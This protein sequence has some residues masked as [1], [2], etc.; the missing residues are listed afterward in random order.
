MGIDELLDVTVSVENR[1]ENSY[2]SHVILTYPAGLSF[3]KFTIL[4]VRH[5]DQFCFKKSPV[6]CFFG[7]YCSFDLKRGELSATLRTVKLAHHEER[8]N[9]LLTN[10]F[11]K[12][13]RRLVLF[14]E[15]FSPLPRQ[16]C[17]KRRQSDPF[18]SFHFRF[19]LLSP[20]GLK[21]MVN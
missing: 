14:A 2:N 21:L 18:H 19:S 9:A 5:Q 1:Q 8:Q 4:Q 20:M 10:P 7:S 15:E 16:S 3:R 13:T 6:N 17:K 11:S 12:A